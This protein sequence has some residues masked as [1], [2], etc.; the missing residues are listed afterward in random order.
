MKVVLRIV[1]LSGI[2]AFAAFS[3]ETNEDNLKSHNIDGIGNEDTISIE[4]RPLG[5]LDFGA[6]TLSC[7]N[8]CG[9]AIDYLSK[10]FIIQSDSDYSELMRYAECLLISSWPQ[11]DFN[12]ST[13]LAGVSITNTI[14]KT[15]TGQSVRK[16]SKDNSLIY[17]VN[18]S[19][20]GYTALGAVYYWVQIPKISEDQE[21]EFQIL[22]E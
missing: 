22:I 20:G 1:F 6:D 21:V 8:N 7:Q 13:I 18:I 16:V 2:F 19:G 9:N 10:Q 3:C 14:C 11:I 15:I 17:S 4:I 5:E 12:Q